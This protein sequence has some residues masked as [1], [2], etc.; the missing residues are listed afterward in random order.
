MVSRSR[1]LVGSS[2]TSTFGFATESSAKMRR[3]HS[4]P[5][6]RRTFL[7]V[8]S[9]ENSTRPSWPRTKVGLSPGHASSRIESGVASPSVSTSR[10][11][12]GK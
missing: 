3:A 2:R 9:P 10:W 6:S 4:P 12:C 7:P 11:S 1:W 8:S 5:D